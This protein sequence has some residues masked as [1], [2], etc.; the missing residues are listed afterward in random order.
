[1]STRQL[2][3]NRRNAAKSTGPKTQ[4][5]KAASSQ[6]ALVHGFT[7][8][9]VVLSTED[10]KL[11]LAMRQ[12]LH[13][14]LRPV[15]LIESGLVDEIAAARWR[16]RRCARLETGLLEDRMRNLTRDLGARFEN[17]DP[18]FQTVMGFKTLS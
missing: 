16:Q 15:G 1:M 10:N 7:A 8:L 12:E 5:G 9:T 4:A 13:N 17:L 2:E 14:E 6:N 3:A 11:F 18:D